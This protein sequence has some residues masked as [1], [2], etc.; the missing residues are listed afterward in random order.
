MTLKIK[1]AF[2]VVRVLCIFLAL[3][4]SMQAFQTVERFAGRRKARRDNK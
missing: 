2:S 1:H 4:V 3:S